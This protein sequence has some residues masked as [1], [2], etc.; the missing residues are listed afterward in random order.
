MIEAI[1]FD[2]DGTLMD[3]DASWRRCVS[4]TIDEVARR[5][6]SADAGE[7]S[8]RYYAAAQRLWKEVRE[9][10]GPPWGNTEHPPLVRRI[11]NEAVR[12]LRASGSQAAAAHAVEIYTRLRSTDAPLYEDVV[13]CLRALSGRY[14]L[15]VITNG[16]DETHLPKVAASGLGGY[17]GSVTTTDCG[18]GKPL[19]AI[20]T[21]ALASLSAAP[22][23]A[24][25][26]GDWPFA[27]VG[28][29]NAAGMFSVW[30]NRTGA[31]PDPGD[32][33]PDA[34]ITSLRELPGVLDRLPE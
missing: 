29:A 12:R 22:S 20:F 8:A 32:P 13:D 10:S 16:S 6:P 3:D 30:I 33:V 28:G 19:R 5:Y 31:A 7:L 34:R 14:R 25:Y 21:H 15:G 27:D 2:W 11:W 24:L 9:V 23:R 17:F 26:V 18:A 1:F 4:A